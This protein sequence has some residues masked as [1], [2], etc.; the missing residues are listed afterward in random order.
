MSKHLYFFL[1]DLALTVAQRNTLVAAVRNYGEE[2]ASIHPHR[3]MQ[4]RI[5]LDSKAV[6]FEAVFQEA[7]LTA[8]HFKA[9]LA[10]I[11]SVSETLITFAVTNPSYGQ[12]VTYSYS[13]TAR[14]RFGVF[15]GA[16]ATWE[17]SRSQARAYITANQAA[18][19]P[20]L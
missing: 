16:A 15:G 8:A 7:Q 10:N 20:G 13:S 5:R 4:S 18:W 14:L 2:N 12:L 11:F 1:E 9:V 3:R 19:E 17:E 6:I